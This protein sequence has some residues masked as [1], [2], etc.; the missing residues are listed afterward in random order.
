MVVSA[1]VP[2]PTQGA[3]VVLFFLYV[4][5]LRQAGFEVVHLVLLERGKATE[6]Q[7]RRYQ[8]L[9]SGRGWRVATIWSER[10]VR[11]TLWSHRLDPAATNALRE[12]L[13]AFRPDILVCLDLLPA[14]L[15]AGNAEMPRVVWLGD[16]NFQ[17]FA[18]NG[19]YG[20][21]EGEIG[22]RTL[23]SSLLQA[24][25]WLPIYRRAMA[26]AESILVAS[27]SSE[28]ALFWLGLRAAYAAYPWPA[29]APQAR[30]ASRSDEVPTF[31][32]CG[33]LRGLGSRSALHLLLDGIY[34]RLRQRLGERRFRIVLCGRTPL[35]D[36][37][38]ASTATKPEVEYLGFVEDLEALMA[39]CHALLAPIQAP[40]GNRSRIVT[41]MAHRLLVIAH[42]S[43]ACGNPDL[44]NGETCYLARRAGTFVTRIERS[45]ERP[46]EVSAIVG[47]AQEVYRRRFA[48][49]VATARLVSEV[50]RLASGLSDQ[51]RL[52]SV[53]E[54][55][56]DDDPT[57]A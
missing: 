54:R 11:S 3:S 16:L 49:G 50:E 7:L 8:E 27:K 23:L 13:V 14:W 52:V 40:V 10:F 29:S 30:P 31:L 51:G 12:S 53:R 1:G 32:F 20:W 42:P 22:L 44:V 36:W 18:Y 34:P 24:A 35:P 19:Y 39:S 38:Q 26:G 43:T 6:E 48:P 37:A 57:R 45:L 47:R 4:E 55:S 21:R 28:A 25:A 56:S 9:A 15:S 33:H 2:H 17:S 41:A 5:A 46:D